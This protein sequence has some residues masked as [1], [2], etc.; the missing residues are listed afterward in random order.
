MRIFIIVL[1]DPPL[2]SSPLNTNAL[3]QEEVSKRRATSILFCHGAKE[4]KN[5]KKRRL[6]DGM[7]AQCFLNELAKT[8]LRC[9]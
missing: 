6:S 5:A 7:R 1:L 9:P 2:T 4:M 3:Q 8:A